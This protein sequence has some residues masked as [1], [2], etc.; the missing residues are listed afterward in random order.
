VSA[1]DIAPPDLAGRTVIVTG[2][3][4]GIGEAYAHAFAEAGCNVVVADIDG[5]NATSVARDIAGNTNRAIAT[6][7]DVSDE[8]ATLAMAE[9]ALDAYGRIDVLINNAALY[10]NVTR[11]IF[12]EL[13]VEEWKRVMDVNV[14]GSFLCAR[15]VV[16]AMRKQ[17]WGRIVNISSSTVAMGRPTF[18]HYVTSK[19]AVVGMTR[20]MAREIGGD[21]IT[22]NCI[23]PGLTDTGIEATGVDEDVRDLI[24]RMQAIP[25]REVP[26]DL[27]GTLLYLAS[28]ASGFVTGQTIAVDGGT[29]HL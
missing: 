10:T 18:L 9:A 13:S 23:M 26:Q 3:G 12:D 19:A 21:G 15:A 24:V 17:S 7:T 6:E 27:V 8:A 29:I 20:S 4:Q 16:P 25:R 1:K 11:A 5:G 22:V 14:T 2:G 28:D